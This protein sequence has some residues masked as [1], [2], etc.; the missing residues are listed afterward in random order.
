VGSTWLGSLVNKMVTHH[1]C[2]IMVIFS[3][4]LVQIQSL[5]IFGF[6]VAK[7]A[8]ATIV[9]TFFFGFVAEKKKKMT[10]SITFFDGFVVK[11]G[12]GNYRHLF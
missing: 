12:D 8:M 11:N 10:I 7:K 6:V 5:L 9:V 1:P 3:N 4:L 2:D